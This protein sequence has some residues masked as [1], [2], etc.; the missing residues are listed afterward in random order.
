MEFFC[1]ICEK[2]IVSENTKY[3]YNCGNVFEIKDFERRFQKI[4]TNI[5]KRFN[6]TK[7]ENINPSGYFKDRVV[8]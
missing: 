7:L 8:L 2:T 4:N 1:L 6:V 5:F 3:Y